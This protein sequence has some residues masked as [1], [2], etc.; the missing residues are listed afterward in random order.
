MKL[1]I[2]TLNLYVNMKSQQQVVDRQ[3]DIY[4]N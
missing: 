3:N 1:S 2:G 4:V